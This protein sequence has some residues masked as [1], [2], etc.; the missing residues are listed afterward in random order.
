MASIA[1]QGSQPQSQIASCQNRPE[2]AENHNP[3]SDGCSACP[4]EVNQKEKRLP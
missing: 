3:Q 4:K 1:V 2:R